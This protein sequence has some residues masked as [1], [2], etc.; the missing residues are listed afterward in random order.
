MKLAVA[1]LAAAALAAMP[2]AAASRAAVACTLIPTTQLQSTVGLSQSTVL[3]QNNT[4][5]R[6]AS[7]INTLCDWGVWSGP[8][9]AGT[10]AIFAA[11]RSGHAAQI[12]LET[13]A[14]HK[15]S[16]SARDWLTTGYPKLTHDF[17][18]EAIAFPGIFSANGLPAKTLRLPHLGHKATGFQAAASGVAKGLVVAVGCWWEDKRHSAV[19]LLDEEAASRPAAA[20]LVAL[21]KIA[22]PKFLG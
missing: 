5:A 18:K 10:Q 9:P 4:T 8:T 3:V 14:P 2:S 21:A 6:I 20:H 7:S 12:G 17:V 15:R 11:A 1:V 22:V 13:W 19:C 16:P